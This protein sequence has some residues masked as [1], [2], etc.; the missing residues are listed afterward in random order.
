MITKI[1]DFSRINEALRLP[2]GYFL[3]NNTFM[4]PISPEGEENAASSVFNKGS[5]VEINTNQKYIKKWSQ[6]MNPDSG[7]KKN[8]EWQST[9]YPWVDLMDLKVYPEFKKNVSRLEESEVPDFYKKGTEM[10]KTF[11][12]TVNYLNKRL[13]EYKLDPSAKIKITIL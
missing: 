10:A 11:T 9:T 12:T 8:G 13:A 3:V 1:N 6:M 7:S 5:I 2:H 4:L